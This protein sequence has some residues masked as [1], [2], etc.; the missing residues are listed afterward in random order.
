[1]ASVLSSIIIS[2]DMSRIT[3]HKGAEMNGN[4]TIAGDISRMSGDTRRMSDDIC[5]VSFILRR[6]SNE[7]CDVSLDFF[8]GS[9]CISGILAESAEGRTAFVV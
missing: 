6:M 2:S 3:G 7:I 4:Q 5:D 9:N 8:G 1:M